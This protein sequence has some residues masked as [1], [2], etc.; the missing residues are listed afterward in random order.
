MTIGERIFELMRKKNMTQKEFSERTNIGQSTI[1]DWKR[2]KR[3]P[4]PIKYLL[5]VMC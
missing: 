4:L 5:F 1:S 3:I 2:K